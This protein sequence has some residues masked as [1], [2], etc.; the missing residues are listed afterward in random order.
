[1]AAC[2]LMIF[3]CSPTASPLPAAD[4][5]ASEIS[6]VGWP[7]V[8]KRRGTAKDLEAMLKDHRPRRLHF[9]GHADAQ[10]DQGE[11]TFGF[12]DDAGRLSAVQPE[13]L[14]ELLS[15]P[16]SMLGLELVFLNGCCSNKLGEACHRAGVRTVICWRT[17]VADKAA[18]IF[19]SA[20][21]R[22]LK[23]GFE[24]PTAFDEAKKAV[25]IETR[26][27]SNHAGMSMQ[28]PKYALI[29]PDGT[30]PASQFTPPP[31][32]AG[33]PELIHGRVIKF[34]SFTSNSSAES[35]IRVQ[36][37]G[38]GSKA[39]IA[40]GSFCGPSGA[41]PTWPRR[42]EHV[43]T[44]SLD[45]PYLSHRPTTDGDLA[46]ELYA[47][48]RLQ[49][50]NP[51]FD[52]PDAPD[53]PWVNDIC[54]AMFRCGVYVPLISK[55]AI[56]GF[57]SLRPDS[58][59]DPLL[60]ECT[61]A[62]ELHER[63]EIIVLPAFVAEPNGTTG[64]LGHFVNHA[65]PDVTVESIRVRC[66][67]HMSRHEELSKGA[68]RNIATQSTAQKRHTPRSIMQQLI[69]IDPGI[70]ESVPGQHVLSKLVSTIAMASSRAATFQRVRVTTPQ[71]RELFILPT[72]L[73][74][75][76]LVS[77][78]GGFGLVLAAR[79]TVNERDVAIKKLTDCFAD[80]SPD[81]MTHARWAL[82]EVLLLRHLPIHENV[83]HAEGVLQPYPSPHS[84][85]SAYLVTDLMDGDLSQ[86]IRAKRRDQA[87]GAAH[88]TAS[89]LPLELFMHQILSAVT[90][91]HAS[92]L[93]HRDLKPA[94]ILTTPSGRL[95]LADFG[96]ARQIDSLIE[97]ITQF[98]IGS[99][100][101]RAPEVVLADAVGNL[102]VDYR[103]QVDMWSVGT[104]L[105]EMLCLVPMAVPPRKSDPIAEIKHLN[106]LLGPPSSA[107]LEAWLNMGIGNSMQ[108]LQ[109][110]GRFVGWNAAQA[111]APVQL[112]AYLNFTTG[113]LNA[114]EAVEA[115]APPQV[116]S[117]LVQLLSYNPRQRPS[118]ETLLRSAIFSTSPLPATLPPFSSSIGEDI[119]APLAKLSTL[120]ALK[121]RFARE[122]GASVALSVAEEQRRVRQ[123]LDVATQHVSMRTEKMLL[124]PPGAPRQSAGSSS[125]CMSF[126]PEL[127]NPLPKTGA[128]SS[129]E[130]LTLPFALS[131]E[132][133]GSLPN[134][135]VQKWSPLA[136][137]PTIE[138]LYEQAKAAY[139]AG[140]A[141][142]EQGQV[143]L[144]HQSATRSLV[145]FRRVAQQNANYRN[146]VENI[147]KIEKL[148]GARG[149]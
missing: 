19:S 112:P 97:S 114:F 80:P 79:D 134:G 115:P 95:K 22:E 69:Q 122:A 110:I 4:E 28:V 101:Y 41:P 147:T 121:E 107:A 12:V 24:A 70:L 31:V 65:G 59:C 13:L 128:Q 94:N 30:K 96:Q 133:D 39:P 56:E 103:E 49:G 83:L 27:G 135:T 10:L 11:N 3:V 140:M 129:F 119:L 75:L 44:E 48:L 53:Q 124:P 139:A 87:A 137:T 143:E 16:A 85:T 148:L 43:L 91:L 67:Q 42:N 58:P 50:I 126:V 14:A 55:A 100:G 130:R 52:G 105:C 51:W 111:R 117:L 76:R 54:E 34:N 21:Y 93:F 71:V 64:Y 118:A 149:G 20:F 37:V 132:T 77:S 60:L 146:T 86:L 23:R 99:A 33:V 15:A 141:E 123:K 2:E 32:C 136:A 72:S 35:V 98:R 104:I 29:D 62:L 73:K 1:M 127:W 102:N 89:P 78:N 40:S 6:Q 9:I 90:F 63:G 142:T 25:T 18:K 17:R 144:A 61:V 113:H 74:P 7:V 47:Q 145:L 26:S 68:T 109:D 8:I 125:G 57:A 131:V 84:F 66:H 81:G 106:A 88:I 116:S 120:D 138:Q 46:S 36:D 82:R 45:R 5:E 108:Q 38:S 92:G